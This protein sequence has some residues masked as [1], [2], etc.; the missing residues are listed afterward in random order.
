M[1]LV[2][3]VESF[4]QKVG[5][6]Y[7]VPAAADSERNFCLVLDSFWKII[8]GNKKEPGSLRWAVVRIV[9]VRSQMI[10]LL[11]LRARRRNSP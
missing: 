9:L 5:L 1:R 8:L 4:D 2:K 11:R 7:L 10:W 6:D 3:S